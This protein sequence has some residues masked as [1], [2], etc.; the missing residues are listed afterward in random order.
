MSLLVQKFGGS[1]VA[2]PARLKHV[3]ALVASTVNRG[4]QVVVVV[5]AMGDTT[6]DLLDLAAA[7]SAHPPARE[8]DMLLATGEQASAALLAM[9]LAAR[10]VSA[11]S[12]SGWQAGIHTDHHHGRAR[13][14]RIDTE[15]LRRMLADRMTPVV[16]GFQG[17]SDADEVTTLGRG[18]SDL[19]AVALAAALEADRLEIFS[20]VAGIYTAD[21]RIVADARQLKS[22]TYDDML[23]LSSLGAQVLQ[24]RAVLYARAHGVTIHARSTFQSDPGTIITGPA[25][26]VLSEKEAP[27]MLT[28]E[29]H[30]VTGVAYDDKV[31]RISLI[32]VPDRPGVAFMV[33]Q[34]L[35]DRHVNVDMIIQGVDRNLV[36]DLTFTVA[37]ADLSVALDICRRTAAELGADRVTSDEQVAK[38]SV[39]G[40]GMVHHP[41]VAATMFRA[42]AE[43]KINIEII[44]CSE[45]KIS[46]LIAKSEGH[47][48]VRAVH[49]AY[50]LERATSEDPLA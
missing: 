4:H 29:G 22:V 40:S 18:G 25:R 16:A 1:S 50:G 6:D 37:R 35:A 43:E 20:D 21:P 38:V 23:D 48:A 8:V 27:L 36:S 3:A 32:G 28:P 44:T 17:M 47:R 9:A 30:T 14:D 49:A 33:F 2:D 31:A 7:V 10:G 11:R 12:L 5:S 42:L 24:G 13:L 45:T 39:V 46:C 34:A 19:T 26:E 41:G 15:R